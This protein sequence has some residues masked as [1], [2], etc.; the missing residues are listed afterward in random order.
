MSI[1]QLEHEPRLCCCGSAPMLWRALVGINPSVSDSNN[2]FCDTVWLH[3]R[4]KLG[5]FCEENVPKRFILL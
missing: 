2:E 1:S 4:A 3:S 5:A